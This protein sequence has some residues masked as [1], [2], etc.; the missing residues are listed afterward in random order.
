MCE[1]VMKQ[2]TT[3]ILTLTPFERDQLRAALGKRCVVLVG[4]M[5]VG[6][7]TIGKQLGVELGL[8]FFDADHEIEAAAQMSIADIFTLYGE[9]EFRQL[10]RRVILRL[11]QTNSAQDCLPHQPIVLA[12][13][14]GAF[15]N[16]ETRATIAAQAISIWLKADLDILMERV[17][18]K[19]NRP[20]LQNDDPRS[21][22]HALMC[23][24]YPVYALADITV[25]SRNASREEV[26][27]DVLMALGQFLGLQARRHAG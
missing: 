26:T 11:L 19:N 22:M 20:L 12:T 25:T 15:M 14:G 24:R 27:G 6:K 9:Q 2:A 5:G 18:R 3:E 13:G 4:L 21:V 10:E 7:S 16:G 23:E 17:L 1:D 8:N